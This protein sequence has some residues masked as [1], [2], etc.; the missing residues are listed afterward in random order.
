MDKIRI[1]VIDDHDIVRHGLRELLAGQPDMDLV[2]D[3][4]NGQDGIDRLRD[5]QPDVV[6]T[7]IAMPV[8]DGLTV[9][10]LVQEILPD[11]RVVVFSM[12]DKEAYVKQALDCGV[13]GYILKT[14]P[15]SEILKAIR[16]AYKGEY[17]LSANVASGVIQKF[18]G[19]RTD[20]EVKKSGYD[21][22]TEREQAVFRLMVEG[23]TI[24]VMAELFCLSP[25]TIEKH[26]S[27][28]MNKLDL[29]SLMD[30][31]KYAMKIGILDPELWKNQ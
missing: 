30:L 22:L 19:R 15:S 5:F 26:R 29:H 18:L 8:M 9:A 16:D 12:H 2:G 1:M 14:S 23:K 4:I 21:L 13:L 31:T 11:A 17:F 28:V 27:N 25:K 24:K 6:I 7:D 10:S 3:A 20:D